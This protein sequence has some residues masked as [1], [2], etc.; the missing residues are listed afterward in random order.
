MRIIQ[1]HANHLIYDVF[2]TYLVRCKKI[3]TFMMLI[4]SKKSIHVISSQICFVTFLT[5]LTLH[6]DAQFLCRI[7]EQRQMA[8]NNTL[9]EQK[10]Q[11]VANISILM[12]LIRN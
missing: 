10:F 6:C 12:E 4:G 3:Q 9:P 1:V 5:D 2:T 8:N 11:T 7:A